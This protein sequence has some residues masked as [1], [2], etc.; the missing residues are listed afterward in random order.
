MRKEVGRARRVA[1]EVLAQARHE[2]VDRARLV[3]ARQLPHLGQELFARKHPPRMGREVSDQIQ[4]QQRQRDLLAGDLNEV[5]L[6][7]DDRP[8]EAQPCRRRSP[9][10]ALPR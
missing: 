8:P 4:L 2:V 5:R 10:A 1:L 7:V 9:W 3:P 6:E